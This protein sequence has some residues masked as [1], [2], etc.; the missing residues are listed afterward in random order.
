[1]P[2]DIDEAKELAFPAGECDGEVEFG[3][4][5]F[6]ALQAENAALV[7]LVPRFPGH[8]DIELVQ[9]APAGTPASPGEADRLAAALRDAGEGIAAAPLTALQRPFY[10]WYWGIVAPSEN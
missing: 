6:L 9:M 10:E 5:S 2:F 4:L 8:T 1:M 7:R 3:P